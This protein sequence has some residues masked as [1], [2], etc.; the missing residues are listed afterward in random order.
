MQQLDAQDQKN[1]TENGS[2][3]FAFKSAAHD[4]RTGLAT[5]KGSHGCR[6]D[7]M[8]VYLT[9]GCIPQKT[10]QR[11]KTYDEG[12]RCRGD[13]CRRLEN[14]DQ[15]RHDEHPPAN[16]QKSSQQTDTGADSAPSDDFSQRRYR[17][18]L[19]VIARRHQH[20]QTCKG[21]H[22]SQDDQK[23]FKVDARID[24][25]ADGGGQTGGNDQRH[26]KGKIHHLFA[27]VG[28]GGRGCG[29]EVQKK[30]CRGRIDL[31]E[32]EKDEQGGENQA[33][34]QA[35]HGQDQ[36]NQKNCG[37]KRE[38]NGHGLNRSQR[39]AV[40]DGLLVLSAGMLLDIAVTFSDLLGAAVFRF[41]FQFNG[42]L[43]ILA[44][45]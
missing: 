30:R 21:Q 15:K 11:G 23:I 34:A 35:H 19:V 16:S 5:S 45:G 22:D 24:V 41:V 31:G 29:D 20:A 1:D 13:F 44:H 33:A 28:V 27:R 18:R 36:R 3:R 43:A 42:L 8:P 7:K 12:G 10:G 6:Q 25:R 4:P 14:V 38:R 26:G 2:D 9:Y 17:D 40:F 39:L 37:D 32:S